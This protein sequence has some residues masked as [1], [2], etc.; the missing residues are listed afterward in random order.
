M[1]TLHAVDVA[2]LWA[3]KLRKSGQFTVRRFMDTLVGSATLD[4]LTAGYNPPGRGR[5]HRRRPGE[6]T[7]RMPMRPAIRAS[8]TCSLFT[9]LCVAAQS[10]VDGELAVCDEVENDYFAD[11]RL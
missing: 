10:Q 6:V 11:L 4:G 2:A 8:R 1:A 5:W 7:V 9:A 3:Q